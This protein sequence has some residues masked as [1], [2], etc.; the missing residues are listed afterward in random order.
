VVYV[1]FSKSFILPGPVVEIKG[2]K[3]KTQERLAKY[4]RAEG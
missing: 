2:G 1:D 3:N 4:K